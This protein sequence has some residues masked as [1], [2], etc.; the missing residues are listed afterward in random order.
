[1]GRV[2]HGPIS[3]CPRCFVAL[4]LFSLHQ[5]YYARALFYVVDKLGKEGDR[6]G[7][8]RP[9]LLLALQALVEHCKNLVAPWA[10]L[11]ECNA[12]VWTRHED[13][14]R[15]LLRTL[16]AGVQRLVHLLVPYV[17]PGA[18]VPLVKRVE[19]WCTAEGPTGGAGV[20]AHWWRG[21]I[22]P[23]PKMFPELLV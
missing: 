2:L 7:Q 4:P 20:G 12:E 19:V 8:L 3:R 10:E 11:G 15:T 6:D 13:Q 21:N 5:T 17:A 1:M 22:P 16:L 18:R 9:R 23:H 14:L